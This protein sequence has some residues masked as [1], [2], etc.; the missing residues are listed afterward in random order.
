MGGE[1]GK[2][3]HQCAWNDASHS[4]AADARSNDAP[5]GGVVVPAEASAVAPS[6]FAVAP[7]ADAELAWGLG[8]GLQHTSAGD[9]LWHWGQNPGFESLMV[10]YPD[11]QLGVVV[12]TNGGPGLA[13]LALARDV[14][15]RAI[16]GEHGRYWM[17]VPGTG[18]PGG[19]GGGQSPPPSRPGVATAQ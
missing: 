6:S 17:G 11:E 16:G 13:G 9:A 19:G 2:P 1:S 14:A 10:G 15:H 4:S 18:W 3:R 5:I 7:S 12:L 8:V